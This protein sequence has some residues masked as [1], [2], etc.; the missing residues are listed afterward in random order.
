MASSSSFHLLHCI[1]GLQPGG[2]ETM[3]SNVSRRL[4][5]LSQG[6]I[7]QS[8]ISLL[9]EGP[10]AARFREVGIPVYSCNMAKS[11]R[12]VKGCLRLIGHARREQPQIIQSWM[13]HGDLA[14]SMITVLPIWKERPRL[15]WGVRNCRV[16]PD[17]L[18]WSTRGILRVLAA[19]S[20]RIPDAVS[21]CAESARAAHTALGYS[22]RRWE[23]IP[24]GIDLERFRPD[25]AL[26][27]SARAEWGVSLD[28]P[29]FGMATR[30]HPVKD[31]PTFA[32]AARQLMEQWPTARF[33]LCGQG[34]SEHS[35]ACMDLLRQ[36]GIAERSIPLGI[37]Q[38]MPRFWN[39]VD[40]AVSSS[41]GE[42]F[43]VGM[44]EA[45]ACGLPAAAT[46]VGDSALLV[47]DGGRIVPSSAPAAL[48]SAMMQCYEDRAA[49]GTRALQRM[50]R[51]FS[52]DACAIRYL[53][54]Y[55]ELMHGQA[56]CRP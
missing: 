26:R 25:S 37:V 11:S 18:P 9:P 22:P 2:A 36:F 10:L 49:L 23:V 19:C 29:V 1:T 42:A 34:I 21:T 13:Y 40:V 54:L 4:Q 44:A 39:G 12:G 16:T 33:V 51:R 20:P 5:R 17:V 41:L 47:G 31:L 35:T 15:V 30:L 32:A 50:Q 8:V 6:A 48:A 55:K 38:E 52:L 28:A 53:D 56:H 27:A 3:C 45:M 24:N 46:D 43:P 7:T 14:A